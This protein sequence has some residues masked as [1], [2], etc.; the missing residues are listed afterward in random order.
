MGSQRSF[1]KSVALTV[2]GTAVPPVASLASAPILAQGLGVAGR[3][4]VAAAQAVA[5]LTVSLAAF[6][7]PEALTFYVARGASASSRTKAAVAA[8]I[9]F[10]GAVSTLGMI[11]AAGPASGG[12]DSL[13]RLIVFSAAAVVPSLLLGLVRGAASGEHMWGLIAAERVLGSVAKLMGSVGLLFSGHLTPET[14]IALVLVCPL[15]GGLPYIRASFGG[16]APRST[17]VVSTSD[18][19]GY[20]GRVWIGSISGILLMRIDQA[21][22]VPISGAVALGLYAVAASI[23]ELP[24]V[25]NSAIR[26]VTF[27]RQSGDFDPDEVM[28]AARITAFLSFAA[29]ATLAVLA[30]FAIPGLFGTEFTGAVVVTWILLIGVVVGTPGSIAGAG[31]SALGHP[32]LRSVSLTIAAVVNVVAI[33]LLAPRAGAEGAAVATIIGNV[34]SSNANILFLNRL[35]RTHW[36]G[37]YAVR[38]QDL[39]DLYTM[40]RRA[41]RSVIARS[42]RVA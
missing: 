3:G 42:E 21:L 40:S 30:P 24:L 8:F 14:A 2:F 4:E 12:S 35:S 22:L 13:Q 26:D 15:I 25:L 33:V 36:T 23:S 28:K 1:A 20:S 41:Y 38:A 16:R 18:V 31:L 9:L 10:V 39:K 19:L 37:F 11:V 6:G 34:V 29:A 7:I 17:A 5:L 27:A 32:G